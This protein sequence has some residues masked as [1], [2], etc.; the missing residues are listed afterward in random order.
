[1]ILLFRYNRK[2]SVIESRSD[3][4]GNEQLQKLDSLGRVKEV[5]GPDP[6]AASGGSY[7]TTEEI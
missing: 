2:F 6:A 5:W 3:P 1:M 4:N 7:R